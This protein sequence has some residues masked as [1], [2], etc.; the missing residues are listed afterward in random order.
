MPKLQEGEEV[1]GFR[2]SGHSDLFSKKNFNY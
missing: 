2:P 1:I